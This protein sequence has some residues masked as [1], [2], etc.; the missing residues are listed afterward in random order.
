MQCSLFSIFLLIPMLAII[1]PELTFTHP[2][3]I[4]VHVLLYVDY[5]LHELRLD[6][7][8]QTCVSLY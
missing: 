6:F 8:A 2:D 7:F 4:I 3:L 1:I 5:L